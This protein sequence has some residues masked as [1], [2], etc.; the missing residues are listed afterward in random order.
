MTTKILLFMALV[1]I[2]GLAVCVALEARSAPAVER[3]ISIGAALMSAAWAIVVMF[4]ADWG[5]VQ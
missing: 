2:L 3:R 5:T 4:T 1:L